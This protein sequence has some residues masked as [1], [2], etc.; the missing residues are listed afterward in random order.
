MHEPIAD[1]ETIFEHAAQLSR[2][3][4]LEKSV[5]AP[6]RRMSEDTGIPVAEILWA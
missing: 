5:L 6:A 3:T 4:E 1:T 2:Q